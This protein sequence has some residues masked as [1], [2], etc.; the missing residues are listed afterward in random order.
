MTLEDLVKHCQFKLGSQYRVYEDE[1]YQSR[2]GGQLYIIED[3]TDRTII[4]EFEGTIHKF[5]IKLSKDLSTSLRKSIMG[6]YVGLFQHK[7]TVFRL[8]IVGKADHRQYISGDRGVMLAEYT[9]DLPYYLLYRPTSEHTR[10]LGVEIVKQ[11]TYELI[12][13][14]YEQ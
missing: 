4:A 14:G 12:N 5:S 10:L 13:E 7:D 9:K 1:G 3:R 2:S 6:W 11:I 8:S